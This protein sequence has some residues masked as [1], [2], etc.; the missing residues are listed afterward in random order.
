MICKDGESVRIDSS[1]ESEVGGTRDDGDRVHVYRVPG[2]SVQEVE[3]SALA[4]AR[5]KS[6][7]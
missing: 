5:E 3:D 7:G 1:C 4:V 6:T 2:W